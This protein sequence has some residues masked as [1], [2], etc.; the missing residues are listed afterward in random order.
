MDLG[1]QTLDSESD[2]VTLDLSQ[3]VYMTGSVIRPV[4]VESFVC[5]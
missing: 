1:C 3:I 2:Y 4:K 5:M